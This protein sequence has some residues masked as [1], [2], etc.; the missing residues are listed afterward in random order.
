MADM[1]AGIISKRETQT[2][3]ALFVSFSPS[4]SDLRSFDGIHWTLRRAIYFYP[5]SFVWLFRVNPI[6]RYFELLLKDLSVT[7]Y[8]QRRLFAQALPFSVYLL[9]EIKYLVRYKDRWVVFQQLL[10]WTISY[11]TS[12][13]SFTRQLFC[14][15]RSVLCKKRAKGMCSSILV[16]LPS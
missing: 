8:S 12:F 16:A 15:I 7:S 10:Q 9:C 11:V 3:S 13:E 5:I 14:T 2:F 4:L 6:I 1:C